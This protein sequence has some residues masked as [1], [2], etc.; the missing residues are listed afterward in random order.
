[1][2][3]VCQVVIAALLGLAMVGVAQAHVFVGAGVGL[4]LA[5]ITPVVTVAPVVAVAPVPSHAPPVNCAPPPAPAVVSGYWGGGA[6]D[7]PP[8]RITTTCTVTGI[9][10]RTELALIYF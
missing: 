8:G 4:P 1:M 7:A 3:R 10:A 2:K 5:P 9:R 6:S